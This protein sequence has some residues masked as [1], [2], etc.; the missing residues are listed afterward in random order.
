ML[1][2]LLVVENILSIIFNIE[3]KVEIIEFLF[4]VIFI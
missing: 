4:F 3:K 1:E 2:L